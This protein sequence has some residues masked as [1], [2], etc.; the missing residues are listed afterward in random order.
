MGDADCQSTGFSDPVRRSSDPFPL[1][2]LPL[3]LREQIYCYLVYYGGTVNLSRRPWEILVYSTESRFKPDT[4]ILR[5]N[6][7]TYSEAMPLLYR[8]CIFDLGS[9][10][11]EQTVKEFFGRLSKQTRRNILRVTMFPRRFFATV[12]RIPWEPACLAVAALLPA[13]QEVTVVLNPNDYPFLLRDDEAADWIV[14]P[15][16]NIR[17]AQKILQVVETS[18]NSKRVVARWSE[19][20]KAADSARRKRERT[21]SR[22]LPTNNSR[23]GRQ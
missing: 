9:D 11:N 20:V 7:Q 23:D 22:K 10:T 3:E 16:S 8:S 19:L 2:D 5:V 1:F 12:P 6:K 21:G 18:P 4:V 15:L 13:L 14:G 17:A